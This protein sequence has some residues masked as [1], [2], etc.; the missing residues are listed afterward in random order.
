[1]SCYSSDAVLSVHYLAPCLKEG[2][3]HLQEFLL[4]EM[5][6]VNV[7]TAERNYED[8]MHRLQR[9]L[10]MDVILP[11]QY[12][13][14]RMI[15][16]RHMVTSAEAFEADENDKTAFDPPPNVAGAEVAVNLVREIFDQLVEDV[17][18]E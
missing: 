1:M 7:L 10:K 5:A 16:M 18:E 4:H 17:E 6:V 13:A 12:Q 11:E 3:Y 14:A 15:A 2:R 8:S 9:L